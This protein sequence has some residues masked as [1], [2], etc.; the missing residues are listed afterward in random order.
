MSFKKTILGEDDG[1]DDDDDDN[2]NNTVPLK[3]DWILIYINDKNR[4]SSVSIATDC[5][6]DDRGSNLGGAGNFSLR[7]RVQTGSGTYTVSFPVD[8]RCSFPWGKAAGAWSCTSTLQTPSWRGAQ[9]KKHRDRFTLQFL[10][11]YINNITYEQLF[12]Q[13]AKINFLVS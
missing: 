6:L 4:N 5:G 11:L 13:R 1:D 9:L 12:G 3:L 7:Y 10:L 8:T 2:Y